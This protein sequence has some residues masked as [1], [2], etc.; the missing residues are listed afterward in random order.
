[1]SLG[2]ELKQLCKNIKQYTKERY[3]K[4]KKFKIPSLPI[5]SEKVSQ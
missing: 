3:E 4:Y 1:M 2:T 5:I